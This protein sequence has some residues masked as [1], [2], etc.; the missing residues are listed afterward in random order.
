MATGSFYSD[1]PN[2]ATNYPA[3]NDTNTQPVT[4][5]TPA[6]SSMYP[7]GQVYTALPTTGDQNTQPTAGNTA[8][9]SSFYGS[10][11]N[12]SATVP[13]PNDPNTQRVTGNTVAPS[14]FYPGAGGMYQTL[15]N[16]DTLTA[17]F[18]ADLLAA[19]NAATASQNSAT[20]SANSASAASTSA[21][22]AANSATA[23]ANSAT[24]ASN[25]AT[26]AANSAS[27]ASTS[28]TNAANSASAA[29]TSASNASTSATNAAN[30]ATAA[31]G[32][33]T[34]AG[35]D[36]FSFQAVWCGSHAVAPT[37]DGNGNA[38]VNGDLYWN[39]STGLYIYNG[40][41]WVSYNPAA[42][43][44]VFGRTG[45]VVAATGDYTVAQ[46]T[47]AAPLASPAFTGT[48]S[49]AGATTQWTA[50]NAGFEVGSVS[51]ANT[52]YIDF[53]SSGNN[54]DYDA[55]IMASSG[56]ASVGAG[57]LSFYAGGGSTFFG[58]IT[59]QPSS[60]GAYATLNPV[61]GQQALSQ[62]ED[63][64]TVKWLAGK[65]TNNWYIIYDAVNAVNPFQIDPTNKII[66]INSSATYNTG[67]NYGHGQCRFVWTSATA[68]T[69]A[70]HDGNCLRINGVTYPIPAAGVTLSNAGL[71][72]NTLYYVYASWNGSA[73][74]LTASGTGHVT[75]TIA[76]N[77]G[78]E[79]MNGNSGQTLVGMVRTN[80][81]AQFV[82][83]TASKWVISWFNRYR[84]VSAGANFSGLTTTSTTA[85]ELGGG[86]Y[87]C[88]GL[89]WADTPVTMHYP[90][91]F[92]CSLAAGIAYC[93]VG[94]DGVG[95]NMETFVDNNAAAFP[96]MG[97]GSHPVQLAEGYHY[98][99]PTGES[100]GSTNTATYWG[101]VYISSWG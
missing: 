45:A 88:D 30:S 89:F 33:A 54:I 13:N 40:S 1:T 42:V 96:S 20:A 3:Q 95:F 63:G 37:T 36:L 18:D 19:Q 71:A 26:A 52:P 31:A 12:Y 68:C 87:R 58:N 80:A 94:V 39:T 56:S 79:V 86:S 82:W 7:G 22:N 2:Y 72:A 93:G 90:I 84:R 32:S 25:S 23:A 38:L 6:K 17:E 43:L 24:A 35:N 67:F 47:G 76:G 98:F 74:V 73:I 44:S 51:A 11:A 57:A 92:E 70:P 46:V 10:V 100:S 62:Y 65:Q 60:A 49:F 59:I 48:A 97:E 75:D 91:E 69:L 4:G 61:A 34:T 55:R 27:A 99:V 50:S 41:A 9:P 8:A 66:Y 77:V 16:S 21:T 101:T 85:V 5:D 78:V 64:G 14:G 53:H 29:A 15:A 81:S 28:A 83:T